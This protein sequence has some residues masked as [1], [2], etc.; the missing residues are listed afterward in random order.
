M[1]LSRC[2]EKDLISEENAYF[3]VLLPILLTFGRDVFEDDIKYV[4][5]KQA[6]SIEKH[7]KGS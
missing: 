4:L 7:G 6:E 3:R 5:Q 1:S 2:I